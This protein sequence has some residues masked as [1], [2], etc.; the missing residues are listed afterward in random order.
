MART[1]SAAQGRDQGASFKAVNSLRD[2]LQDPGV[3]CLQR[4]DKIQSGI[5][6]TLG[7]LTFGTAA[8]ALGPSRLL[9]HSFRRDAQVRRALKAAG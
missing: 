1:D 8:R 6:A 7:L 9:N 4:F 3:G 5:T 2:L